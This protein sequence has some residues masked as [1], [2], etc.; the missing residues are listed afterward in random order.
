MSENSIRVKRGRPIE[1]EITVPGDKSIS[2]RAAMFAAL[3]NG[4]CTIQNFLDGEDCLSTLSILQQLG[5]QIERPSHHE[6]VIHGRHGKFSPPE[7]DL[8]C[9]NSGT[10][11]RLMTGLLAGQDFECRL[12]GDASLSRRPMKRVIDPLGKM[13]AR[14]IAEGEGNTPPL[15]VIGG[16]LEGINYATP[17]ASAQVKS[18]VL[19]AGLAA[20]GITSV[21]EPALSR[22]HTERMLRYFLV[23][24]RRRE[25]RDHPFRRPKKC[26]VTLAGRQTLESRDF[27][28][29]GD[30]SSAAFWLVAT[31]ARRGSRT[32][33][34]NVGLNPT[35]TAILDVLVRMGARVR[36]VVE[37]VDGGEP[38]GVIDIK[39]APLKGVEIRGA[40]IANL[41]DELP[42]I[43]VAAALAEGETVIADAAELR[44]KESD[45]ISAI[46]TNLQALGVP[47]DE[48][49][50][51]MTIHGGAK[52]RGARLQSFGD[53]RIAMAFAV[54]GLFASGST[55]IEDTSCVQTSYPGFEEMLQRFQRG[56]KQRPPRP[57]KSKENPITK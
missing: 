20:D 14:V 21:T 56:G 54:A 8:D 24:L 16:A 27:V 42:I 29:P 51:G 10:T 26:M 34:T 15:R 45:R 37:V 44:V 36:E 2:H 11:M 17:V 46:A 35:R 12:V 57:S 49:P 53:H 48:A 18:A 40:E 50:D 22:D 6:V 55:I 5:V 43:A 39:G 41:I 52:L 28:V 25:F 7:S 47:V 3:T 38:W 33:I 23:K 19:L 30:I 13:G 1:T 31:A 4:T 9:G 32:I